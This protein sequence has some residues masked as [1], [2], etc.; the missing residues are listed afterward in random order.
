M[1]EDERPIK[2]RW[3]GDA[4]EKLLSRELTPRAEDGDEGAETAMNT[5]TRQKTNIVVD[6]K[7]EAQPLKKALD[8]ACG[9]SPTGTVWMT[10]A[11]LSAFKR[12]RAEVTQAMNERGWRCS[13]DE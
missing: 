10:P 2:V 7:E 5:L 6:S 12:V 1:S 4:R 9:R 3:T 13:D 8:T 11:H